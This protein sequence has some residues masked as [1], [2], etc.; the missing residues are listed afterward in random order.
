MAEIEIKTNGTSPRFSGRCKRAN[1]VS[2][3][4][5]LNHWWKMPK[6]TLKKQAASPNELNRT[7]I[8]HFFLQN[9]HFMKKILFFLT[10]SIAMLTYWACNKNDNNMPSQTSEENTKQS[11]HS[12]AKLVIEDRKSGGTLT[13]RQVALNAKTHEQE[14]LIV[15]LIDSQVGL[16]NP[17]AIDVLL[18]QNPLMEIAYPSFAF[19]TNET[20][21]QHLNSIQYYVV[22]DDETDPETVS[23]LPAY[24]VNGNS[25]QISS[26]F[27][28]S[29]RYAVIKIDEA[30]DAVRDGENLTVK[31]KAIPTSLS[32]FSPSQVNG[33]VK[34]YEEA[35]LMNAER[36]DLGPIYVGPATYRGGNPEGECDRPANK[37][38]Q[39]YK[40]RFSNKDAV[41][42][43]ES[44]FHLP[45]VELFITYVFGT[46]NPANATLTV[47]AITTQVDKNW[48]LL[49]G[50]DWGSVDNINQQIRKW[51]G[52]DTDVWK[53]GFVERDRDKDAEGG[54]SFGITPSY[55]VDKVWG[56]GVPIS[57][58]IKKKKGD[59]LAG[60]VIID[61]CDTAIGEGTSYKVYT[62]GNDGMY[63]RENFQN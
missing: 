34:Y 56:I 11:L 5:I 57:Y 4:V 44:G 35:T 26:T 20:F 36:K 46:V 54:W 53:V 7:T 49:N 22:L 14:F 51:G 41:K 21:Q 12:L 28:E 27:N 6:T 43:I 8:I 16:R 58:T 29:I 47:D 39:L 62:G 19:Q 13:Q 30:H 55:T 50:P 40:I 25:V 45:N 37:K 9:T 31:G 61:Y 10:L 2:R 59:K 18:Q 15:D 63:F 52:L 17:S 42:V 48:S 24:D 32:T 60:E 38:D 3:K 33:N 1:L 23:T